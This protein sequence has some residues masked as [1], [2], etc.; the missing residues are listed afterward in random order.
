[1][2]VNPFASEMILIVV[3]YAMLYLFGIK[4]CICWRNISLNITFSIKMLL[5]SPLS[6]LTLYHMINRDICDCSGFS[7]KTFLGLLLACNNYF[8]Y[9]EGSIVYLLTNKCFKKNLH[10]KSRER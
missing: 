10:H 7:Y 8:F 4:G 2:A 1:M 6:Q 9:S 5:S 3:K